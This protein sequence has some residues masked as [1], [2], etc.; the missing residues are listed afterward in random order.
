MLRNYIITFFR[1]LKRNK[2]FSFIN[3]GGLS[4]GLA[5]CLLIFYYL[6]NEL[7]YDKFHSGY[8]NIYRVNC[9][10]FGSAG[11]AY[12]MVNTPPALAAGLR[13][14][15]PEI[16]KSS[17][18]RYTNRV[19]LAK[20][21]NSFYEANGF[22]AD[23]VFLDIFS[24][25][26]KSGNS[27]TALDLPNSIVMTEAMARKYF[28]DADPLGQNIIMNN[29][30]PLKVTGILDPVPANSHIQFD[31]LI[32]FLTYRVPPGVVAD[33]SSWR[34]LGFITYV[35]LVNNVN[36]GG[37]QNKINKVIADN[38]SPGQ[39]PHKSQMQPLKDIYL[40]SAGL[41]D[42][43]SS[44]LQ[45]GNKFSIYS[46]AVI[47]FLI[48]LIAGFNFFNMTS[49]SL[50]KRGREI[51]LR[52]VLGAQ[53]GKLV[54]QLL[55]ESVIL[56][57]ISLILA[58]VISIVIFV[59]FGDAIG[60]NPAVNW[61]M[62]ML[63]LPVS[64]VV[65]LL[66]G[67]FT[68]L[69]PALFLSNIKTVTAL[70]GKTGIGKGKGSRLRNGLIV[71]QF[72]ISIGLIVATIVITKQINHMREQNLGFDKENVL[73]AKI[74]PGDMTRYYDRFK[75][76]LTEN[77]NIVSVSKS[78]RLMGEPWPVNQI[79]VEGQD[80][81]QG[82][83][84]E[85][86]WVGYDFLKTMGITLKE[87]RAFS[88]DYAGDSLHAI[89]INEK[90]VEYLGL[91][92]PIGKRV[93]FFSFDGPRTIIGVVKDFN[94]LS[95]YH[96]IT[97]AVLVVPF[98]G[99]ENLHIR[100]TAGS[101]SD[102]VAMVKNVWQDVAPGVP[103]EINFMDKHL[104]QLYN[105][106]EELSKLIIVFSFFAVLLACLGLLGLTA[107]MVNNRIKEVGIRKV[108]G[109]SLSSIVI[110][111]VKQ[112]VVIV[113]VAVIISFPLVIYVL[114]RWLENYAYHIEVQWWMFILAGALALIS[115][116][117]TVGLQV[118]KAALANPI[119]AIKYE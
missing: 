71:A 69:Y 4:V 41:V 77:S 45:A 25:G 30:V 81:S 55:Y 53:K 17:Q 5:G 80:P 40:G 51:G 27:A 70:K 76:V 3:I 113:A 111:F 18:L 50:I 57:L 13:G 54:S 94:F 99:I 67:V 28:G 108:L 22:Y 9:D 102:K 106:E 10:Y 35:E 56:S 95:L 119:K 44:P 16:T 114:D 1:Y 26:L 2:S 90:A 115:A 97:P 47:A 43:L 116:L 96:D 73:T 34:W 33:L 101:I 87:G 107:S 75:N 15:I 20:D 39:L 32:S 91:T 68:G 37:V 42:D 66:L 46:F 23:S 60:W 100:V 110:M 84:I 85:A 8:E 98:L 36:P 61:N 92:D 78:G 48:L 64:F 109:A 93:W 83:Q 63:I 62:I 49:A 112:Y 58:Y 104:E 19:L 72:C 21:D 38:T 12:H 103:I 86:N 105:S 59:N 118:I 7:S 117:L 6:A 79:N 88:K 89:I 65:A 31:F 24:F 82:K 14:V 52:K 11:E 74:L 29:E